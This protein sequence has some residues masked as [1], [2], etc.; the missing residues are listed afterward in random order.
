MRELSIF[1]AHEISSINKY[2]RFHHTKAY[3]KSKSDLVVST[4]ELLTA[5]GYGNID[6]FEKHRIEWDQLLR[7][8]PLSYLSSI[9]VDMKAITLTIEV[10][11]EEYMQALRVPLYPRAAVVRLMPTV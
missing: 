1:S 7:Q 5:C 10:D 3:L 8:V 2:E 9:G 11:K 4:N 6:K